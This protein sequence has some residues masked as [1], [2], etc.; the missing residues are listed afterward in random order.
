MMTRRKRRT[1]KPAELSDDAKIMLSQHSE[2]SRIP[3]IFRRTNRQSEEV[4]DE[5]RDARVFMAHRRSSS[6]I[7]LSEK[8]LEMARSIRS[9]RLSKDPQ[10]GELDG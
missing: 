10:D 3:A 2:L 9:A 4:L 5:L 8:G 7:I 1:I 6:A